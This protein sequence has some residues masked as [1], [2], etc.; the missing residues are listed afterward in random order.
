M[1]PLI[2]QRSLRSPVVP[3][4]VPPAG[5]W[6]NFRA[7]HPSNWP[8]HYARKSAR[9]KVGTLFTFGTAIQRFQVGT[10][11]NLVHTLRH[12]L[13]WRP[14]AKLGSEIFPTNP[15]HRSMRSPQ[16][17]KK[18]WTSS[19]SNRI[20]GGSVITW[21]VIGRVVGRVVYSPSIDLP[22]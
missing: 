5:R 2:L 1:R 19:P 20:S 11:M 4:S 9:G 21:L 18:F 7:N 8:K 6:G 14:L 13:L 12:P 17:E 22:I 16:E 10:D 15:L 3:I